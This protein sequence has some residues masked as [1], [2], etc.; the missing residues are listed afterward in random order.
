V[1]VRR[2][3]WLIGFRVGEFVQAAEFLAARNVDDQVAGDG[4]EPRFKFGFGVVLVA[5]LKDANPSL[6]EKVFGKRRVAGEE[7]KITIE[8]L[9]VLLNDAIEKVRIAAAEAS[10]KG[11]AFVSHEPGEKYRGPRNR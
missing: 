6:L 9:L 4:K 2:L 1:F 10:G 11:L 8:A 3:E 5:A 7:E